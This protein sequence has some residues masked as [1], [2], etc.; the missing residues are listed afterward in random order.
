[1]ARG[2]SFNKDRFK[3]ARIY[4]GYTISELAEQTNI[5]KQAI[6]QFENGKA[7]PTLETM[8]SFLPMLKFPMEFFYEK[9]LVKDIEIGNTF[10]RSL[11]SATKKAR[12]SQIEKTKYLSAICDYLENFINFPVLNLPSAHDLLGSDAEKFDELR[13]ITSGDIERITL[14]LRNYWG[15]GTEPIGNMVHLLEK[16]GLIVTSLGTNSEKIDAFSQCQMIGNRERYIVVLGNDTHSAVRRQFTAAHEL[17]H[18]ILHNWS[19]DT[20]EYFEEHR[21]IEKQADSFAGALLL[22]KEAFIKD[23]LYPIN[24]NF[25]VELK[26]KWNVAIS[27]MIVRAFQLEVITYNQYQHLMR[28][29]NAKGMKIREPLDEKIPVPQPMVLPKAV[30]LLLANKIATSKEITNA[31]GLNLSQ[32]MVEELLGLKSGTLNTSGQSEDEV[33]LYLADRK[34]DKR[35]NH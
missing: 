20:E 19:T 27:A 9:D 2:N 5:S 18:I 14:A 8:M 17:A 34:K 33:L 28:Q 1:M 22:P 35:A 4:A 24:L 26:K 23:L 16:N 30:A 13:S 12:L 10:F 11:V 15:V 3:S 29:M 32:E 31:G 21:L 7:K 6:S 25:Y